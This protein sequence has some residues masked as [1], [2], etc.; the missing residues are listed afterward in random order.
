MKESTVFTDTLG[1][2]P[3]IR[4]LEC[5]IINR[6]LDCCLTDIAEEAQV[7]WTTLHRIWG[8]LVQQRM[9]KQTRVIGRAKLFIINKENPVVKH[10]I[11]L[12][13]T[14]LYQETEKYFEKENAK[15]TKGV[16]KAKVSLASAKRK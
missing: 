15:K 16:R 13:D 14:L 4:V 9:V 5:L 1:N 10:L 7:S 11:K 8:G 12:F 3:V 6:D 2:S